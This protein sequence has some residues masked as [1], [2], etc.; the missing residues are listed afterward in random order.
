MCFDVWVLSPGFATK[1]FKGFRVFKVFRGFF[2]ANG[3]L[4]CYFPKKNAKIRKIMCNFVVGSATLL[5]FYMT[6][7]YIDPFQLFIIS[8]I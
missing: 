7:A 2:S 8:N 4:F 6:W 3:A 1:D 5:F